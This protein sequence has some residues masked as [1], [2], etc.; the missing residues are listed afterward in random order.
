MSKG[1]QRGQ[2]AFVT[3]AGHGIGRGI[4]EAFGASGA[5]VVVADREIAAA[6][7]VAAAISAQGGEALAVALDVREA[8]S[9]Q[10]AVAHVSD[11][12]DQID[13]LVNNAGIYP[14]TPF[15]DMME[16][17]WDA[18]FDTNVKGIFLVGQAVAATMVAQ[19]RGGRIINISS[20]AAESGRAGAAHYCSTKAAVNMLT[21]VMALELSPRGITVNAVAPGLIEVPGWDLNQQYIEAML[22][23]TPVGRLGQPKDVANVVL[24]LASPAAEFITGSVYGVDGGAMAGRAV[25][26]SSQHAAPQPR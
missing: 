8:Q 16:A 19:G 17:E 23:A 13:V 21:R 12:F 2:V 6:D 14:N 10:D 1:D 4:A 25:P 24:F 7:E 15:L 3:G 18:V 9:A 26:L 20:G 5:T 11:R 22:S